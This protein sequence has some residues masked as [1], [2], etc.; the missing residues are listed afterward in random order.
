MSPYF[1]KLSLAAKLGVANSAIQQ[2][3]VVNSGFAITA[4]NEAARNRLL[5]EVHRLQREEN[6]VEGAPK[7]DLKLDAASMWTSVLAP[8]VPNYLQTLMDLPELGEPGTRTRVQLVTVPVSMEMIIEEAT[9]KTG[10]API[11][12]RA[13]AT[14]KERP[15]TDWI[16]HFPTGKP[17]LGERLF[18]V[19]M[20]LRRGIVLGG[21]ITVD[22]IR[23]DT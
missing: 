4:A 16:I 13:L 22:W 2:V 1:V 18:V 11:S 6:E 7:E 14:R 10:M 15:A 8:N 23:C 19:V 21:D 3:T 12:A 5:E 20:S 17:K 9:L